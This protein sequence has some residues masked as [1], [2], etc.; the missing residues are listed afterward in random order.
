MMAPNVE[1]AEAGRSRILHLSQG[2]LWIGEFRVWNS[3]SSLGRVSPVLL[4]QGKLPAA[5][6][7][8]LSGRTENG[9][10]VAVEGRPGTVMFGPYLTLAPGTYRF[11]ITYGPASGSQAWD[12]CAQINGRAT[13]IAGGAL[14]PTGKDNTTVEATLT[15]K[16]RL[17]GV[18]IRAF[19]AG[20]GKLTL[21]YVGVEPLKQKRMRHTG[22]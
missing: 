8:S 9:S 17:R 11:T 22:A 10:I 16:K 19:Y 15:F 3:I 4:M 6:L 7:F 1:R 2:D 5:E 14:P 20:E 13:R 21:R 12:I 18:E